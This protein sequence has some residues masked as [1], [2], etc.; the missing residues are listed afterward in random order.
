MFFHVGLQG[1]TYVRDVTNT[2]RQ[3]TLREVSI[4]D[5][6]HTRRCLELA[7]YQVWKSFVNN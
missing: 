5:I 1:D 3:Y 7:T 6:G 2:H 4:T